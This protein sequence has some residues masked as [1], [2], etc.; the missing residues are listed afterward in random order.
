MSNIDFSYKDN[1]TR[2]EYDIESTP[3]MFTIVFM[4]DRAVTTL[5]FG[6]EKYNSVT[7]EELADNA[8]LY[9]SEPLHRQAFNGI[10]S[11][12]DF[13]YPVIRV[14][15]GD[16]ESMIELNRMLMKIITC[17][18]LKT[19]AEYGFGFME[20]CAWNSS[21]YDLP[22]IILTRMLVDK[23]GEKLHPSHIRQ[24]SDLIIHYEGTPWQFAPY[25]EN[26]TK[27]W[28]DLSTNLYRGLYNQA[29]Y[30]DGH[31]DWARIAKLDG[32]D[33]GSATK[34]PP[35]LKK[36][37]GRAGLTVA[38]NDLISG[39]REVDM[40]SEEAM[41]KD[42]LELMYYNCNDVYTTRHV[43]QNAT[44]QGLLKTR[45]I[46]REQYPYTSAKSVPFDRVSSSKIPERDDT[47]ARIAGS[48]L[49]GPRNIKPDDFDT[50]RYTFP[51]PDKSKPGSMK[52]VDLLEYMRDTEEFMPQPIYTFF[53]H[54]RGKD[55]A[56][57]REERQAIKSQ[58]LTHDST[59][60]CPYYRDG[61]PVDSYIRVSTG[62]AHG[63][64]M[65][66]LSH[67][68][69]EEVHNWIISDAGAADHEKPTVDMNE[70]LHI[71]WSSFYPV[72]AS[73]MK[74][75]ETREGVDRY[76]RI[77]EDR[78]K[79]KKTLPHDK[80]TWTPEHYKNQEIQN[81]LKFVLNN[82][83]GAGNTHN[84]YAL[85]PVDNKT[86]SMR[87]VGNMHIWC[88][89]QRLTQAGAFVVSTNTD[90]IYI[91]G[92]S[93]ER[94]QEIIDGYVEDYGMGVDP[95]IVSRFINRDTS[96]RIEIINGNIQEVRGRMRHGH[97]MQYT[98]DSIGKNVPYPL[99]AAHAAIL[100]MAQDEDWLQKPYDKKL[101]RDTVYRLH[102]ESTDPEAWFHLHKGSN[103]SLLTVGGVRQSTINRVVLTKPE[104][105]D[106]IALDRKS[107]LKKSD[108]KLVYNYVAEHPDATWDDLNRE[109]DIVWADEVYD[110]DISTLC[111]GHKV[112][113][114]YEKVDKPLDINPDP[115]AFTSD[116]EFN[117]FWKSNSAASLVVKDPSNPDQWTALKSWREGSLT[118]YTSNHGKI[119]NTARELQEFD[120]SEI[121]VDAYVTWAENLLA[122]WKVSAD[123]P[124]IGMKS[125]D[126][127]VREKKTASS[128]RPTKKQVARDIVKWLYSRAS[129][130]NEDG[131]E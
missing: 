45:D 8:R 22:L 21:R 12:D 121:D 4:H 113:E 34:Y 84:P 47:A 42:V 108:C 76:T 71:D 94:T 119:L 112:D 105:G 70:V 117:D 126:D 44:I 101:M 114:N 111:I 73:K 26:N 17:K 36:E 109:F 23:M 79:I 104:F 15:T 87:L 25:I 1:S 120:M 20:Y 125:I 90:G 122:G 130:R 11:E 19:D 93:L 59:L 92:I 103:S 75:Y 51:V 118:G 96:N 123:I 72:M 62:G 128:K 91:I 106:D 88:L 124:E 46:I 80:A 54:F 39:K 6:D 65:A 30:A 24:V 33:G 131:E 82:A 48:V 102:E 83:T 97:H 28:V 7:N 43:A 116:E 27:S 127:T 31:I 63:S 66:G 52:T 58:P 56:R 86:L 53:D 110:A 107:Q 14:H 16:E 3:D 60:N 98:D 13:D 99:V 50:V 5:F 41:K 77:I 61:K 29:M 115:G 64:V 40:S 95:E 81:G 67:K 57:R 10:N 55:T 85:L 32:E 38:T 89:A 78:I 37:G 69:P 100:Y 68:T 35:G 18:P 129:R 49:I 9:M 74:L 2:V